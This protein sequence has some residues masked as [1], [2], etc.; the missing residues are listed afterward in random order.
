MRSFIQLPQ[1]TTKFSTGTQAASNM[2]Q[3][4][5]SVSSQSAQCPPHRLEL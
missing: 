4:D 1:L 5:L 2:G 3:V